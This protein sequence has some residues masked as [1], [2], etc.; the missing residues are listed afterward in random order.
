MNIPKDPHSY[1]HPEKAKILNIDLDLQVD[2]ENKQLKGTACIEFETIGDSNQLILDTKSLEIKTVA[3]TQGHALSWK[4]KKPD[5]HL[6]SALI[7]DLSPNIKKIN[8]QYVTSPQAEALQWLDTQQTEGK[9]YPFLFTQS[10]A[11]LAR[12]WMPLQDSPGIRFTFTAR[13]QVPVGMM[14]LMSAV[15]PQKH[16]IDGIYHFDMEQP[17][18]GY[19]MSLAVGN[20]EF[21]PV[22]PR[23][24]VYAE[25]QM[26]DKAQYEFADMEKMLE[27]AENLYGP[28]RWGRY[29]LIVLPPSFP[30]GGMENPR[31]TFATPTVIA[32]D[33][34]LTSLVAHELAHSWSGNL[35]TN[36]TWNDFWLNEGFTVYFEHRIM[37]A[38]YGRS[39]S[40]MLAA[41]SRQDLINEVAE[42]IKDGKGDETR[43]KLNLTGRDPDDGVTTIAYDK[44]YFFLRSLEDYVGREIFD[45]F[46]QDY[47]DSYAFRSNDTESFLKYLN[48]NLFVNNNLV[49]EPHVEQWIYKEGLPENMPVVQSDR[50][51]RVHDELNRFLKGINASDLK[52][53]NSWTTHEWLHF[54]KGLPE[55]LS[56]G[57]MK[58]L[59]NT[60][61][62]TTSGN[63][64]IL[65]AWFVPVINNKYE[66]G[67]NALEHFLIH[68]GRRKFL[69]PLYS[70]MIKTEDGEKMA[71]E[72]YKKARPNYHFVSSNSIDDLLNWNPDQ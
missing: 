60:F 67:Y 64:E 28:Y 24:G 10:Q 54:L 11:I 31:I 34:S 48:Q 2:F 57:Q 35:V 27:T 8:I 58:D 6:G 40:E 9:E 69:T 56:P 5:K 71:E 45:K 44:G 12:S 15:N 36:A 18:P 68:T 20:I 62:F 23:T 61:G 30:F 13:I 4:L 22:G 51:D 3:D 65:G 17:I 41:L 46:L 63:S 59:D 66:S 50:F 43:L 38:L 33:R 16:T 42:F 26:L 25:P 19:L 29:D 39:Y 72:I 52:D 53:T 55:Q 14:A 47:F 7:I 32:G 49:P 21:A 37:E 1:A 70:A